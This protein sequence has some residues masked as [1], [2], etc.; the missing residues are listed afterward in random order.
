MA[1]NSIPPRLG[2]LSP[3][4]FTP[5]EGEDR[6]DELDA[7][8]PSQPGCG[9]AQGASV[10]LGNGLAGKALQQDAHLARE[11]YG[12]TGEPADE[13]DDIFFDPLEAPPHFGSE[14]QGW[15]TQLASSGCTPDRVDAEVDDVFHDPQ[16]VD[17]GRS[18]QVTVADAEVR[19]RRHS[20]L[21][22][23]ES[24]IVSWV[25]GSLWFPDSAWDA[26]DDGDIARVGGL[27]VW[28]TLVSCFASDE[29]RGPVPAS[30]K[31]I[32]VSQKNTA[33]LAELSGQIDDRLHL[34][35]VQLKQMGAATQGLHAP[36]RRNATELGV[37]ANLQ[38]YNYTVRGYLNAAVPFLGKI[39]GIAGAASA[40]MAVA[41]LAGSV[42][43]TGIVATTVLT[44]GYKAGK[45][46]QDLPG[47][48]TSQAGEALIQTV[49]TELDSL[50]TEQQHLLMQETGR[51]AQSQRIEAR[52]EMRKLHISQLKAEF[53]TLQSLNKPALV[54]AGTDAPLALRHAVALGD[55]E[56]RLQTLSA[57]GRTRAAFSAFFAPIGRALVSMGRYI[58]SL[59]GLPSR[60]LDRK[61]AA[62]EDEGYMSWLRG[63]LDVSR[64]ASLVGDIEVGAMLR[65][66]KAGSAFND[67]QIN[68]QLRMGEN[69]LQA[70]QQEPD[71]TFG[72]VVYQ[73][74]GSAVRHAVSATL[75]TARAICWY[76]EALA[77]SG[78]GKGDT[79]AAVTRNA[80]GSMTVSDPGMKLFSFL[81]SVPTAYPAAKM[82]AG[83]AALTLR[84]DDHRKGMPGGMHGLAFKLVLDAGGMPQL[85]LSFTRARGTPVLKPLAN[86]AALLLAAKKAIFRA[87]EG[88]LVRAAPDFSRWTPQQ[89]EERSQGITARLRQQQALLRTETLQ[90]EQ[91]ENWRDPEFQPGVLSSV[92]PDDVV[93][94]R[95]N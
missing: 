14:K 24:G 19:E 16:P 22:A 64:E 55:G 27:G 74:R 3:R 2:H 88:V 49:Y 46:V 81:R 92:Q 87:G 50:L 13:V 32:T 56:Q 61:A 17:P 36:Q 6:A 44:G 21:H 93:T 68:E 41:P 37:F 25:F 43:G 18:A 84:I 62:L 90:H 48:A 33:R 85:H 51:K 60:F 10:G 65:A 8:L 9:A 91:L 63:M 82:E 78:A 80:D 95:K 70:L 77:H 26:D 53:A 20:D 67:A 38:C 30:E 28:D 42:L 31:P 57:L 29:S 35:D 79:A 89:R 12:Q 54:E 69:L 94:G 66:A 75:T 73:P 71:A 1:H 7:L 40:G 45:A 15:R 59:P 72:R 58:A 86:D 34:L 83:D 47:E 4:Y 39:A 5:L 11:L 23:Q 76:F 52:L